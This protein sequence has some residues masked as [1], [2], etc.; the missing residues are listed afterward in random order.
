MGAHGSSEP[1]AC[2]WRK[3]GRR[4][5][6]TGVLRLN[7]LASIAI[8]IF[9]WP[10]RW[11]YVDLGGRWRF[12]ICDSRFLMDSQAAPVGFAFTPAQTELPRP[13]KNFPANA[14]EAGKRWNE[15][16][17]AA[18]AGFTVRSSWFMVFGCKTCLG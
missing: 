12:L 16:E 6:S 7:G 14:Q 1:T 4:R 17:N 15:V 11:I 2:K 18:T 9:V 3:R 10:D 5:V 8:N 13:R